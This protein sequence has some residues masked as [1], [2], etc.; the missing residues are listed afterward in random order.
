MSETQST[1]GA[2]ESPADMDA[3]ALRTQLA[4]VR[5]ENERLRE[6]YARAR[7][8]SYRR[9]ASALVL[10]GLAAIS[11]GVILTGVREVLFVVGAIGVFGGILTWY[12]TPER[13]LTVGVAE[14]VYSALAA[15]GRRLQEELGLQ[16][17]LVYVPSQTG[18]W[19]FLPAHHDVSL[20]DELTGGFQLLE[21]SRGVALTPTGRA[22]YD[23]FTAA[24]SRSSPSS[25]RVV[26]TQLGDALV[27][28]FEIADAVTVDESAE[29]DRLV[30]SIDGVAFGSLT[31]FDHP[32]VSVLAC[33]L[34]ETQDV[35]VVVEQVD[36]STVA[37]E[38]D[39]PEEFA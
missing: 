16:E 7:R 20:P 5:E 3:D 35:P 15:N 9:T 37:F 36:D 33:G 32:A 38:F 11:G 10:I 17:T 22:L 28:Q 1:D 27:E 12:L 25:R 29:A 34:A 2:E 19:L 26:A 18:S 39:T 23:E 21:D 6:E 8:T 4:V 30:V 31:E 13:V 14:S 24:S